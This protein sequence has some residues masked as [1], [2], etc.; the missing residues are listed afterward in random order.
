ML[1]LYP[2]IEARKTGRLKVTDLHEIYWEESG[3]PDGLPIIA[4]H[5]G[6]GGGSNP[7]M[8]RFFD[9]EIYRI[10]LFDQRGC[11]R[12]TPHS[13]LREN[14]TWALVSD[15]EAIR[16]H[17][18]IDKWVVFGGSWGST[19]SLSYAVTHTERVL[20]LILRGIFLITDAEIQWFYQDG[21]SRLFPDA[22]DRYVAPIPEA[23]R[24]DLLHAFHKRLISD[25]RQ[26]RLAAAKAWACWE[27]ETISIQGPSS[28]PAKF[29]EDAFADAFARIECHYFVNKGFFEDDGWLLKQAAEKL[30]GVPGIIV[31]GRYDVVTPL[32]TAW[33]LTKVW[34]DA[35]LHIVSDAGHSSLDSGII[36]QLIRATRSFAKKFG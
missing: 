6:P 18:G 11:G 12:S 28:R 34:P 36:D 15:M 10:I 22:Y 1:K 35:E 19:L 9:P 27:G 30:K 33:A 24:G 17:L 20:G 3:N 8:R 31:H 23:E 29:E 5:G 32:S 16:E 4:L 2:P 13:E 25:N 14:D 7:E 21:A 26:E